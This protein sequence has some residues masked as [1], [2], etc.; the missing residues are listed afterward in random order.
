MTYDVC[1]PL[2]LS[3]GN[4]GFEVAD[5]IVG[6]TAFIHMASRLAAPHSTYTLVLTHT[7]IGPA[8]RWPIRRTMLE[9]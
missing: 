8:S 5:N 6:N 9:I 7:F 4:A 1:L 2:S 3:L